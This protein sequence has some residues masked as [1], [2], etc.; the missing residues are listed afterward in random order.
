MVSNLKFFRQDPM[1]PKRDRGAG[2]YYYRG[3]LTSR[4]HHPTIRG[5]YWSKYEEPKDGNRYTKPTKTPRGKMLDFEKK[6]P[7]KADY[8]TRII[9]KRGDETDAQFNQRK[10]RMKRRIRT[11][12]KG[13]ER[14]YKGWF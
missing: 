9:N 8:K 13:D 10:T 7:H 12:R 3:N 4:T 2:W 5:K 14:G 6:K 11:T 1:Y